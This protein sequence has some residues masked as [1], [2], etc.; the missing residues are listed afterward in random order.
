MFGD[1]NVKNNRMRYFSKIVFKARRDTDGGKRIVVW[2]WNGWGLQEANTSVNECL[3]SESL[4]KMEAI[5]I[6]YFKK[7]TDGPGPLFFFLYSMIVLLL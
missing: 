1:I 6:T 3:K 4:M 5:K 7:W 2:D